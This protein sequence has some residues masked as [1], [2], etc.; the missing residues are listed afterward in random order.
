MDML[1][2]LLTGF[3]RVVALCAVALSVLLPLQAQ[4]KK[5]A[6]SKVVATVDGKAITEE[7]L[8]KAAASEL[9]SL[10]MQ[11]LQY[12]ANHARERH[13]VL[14]NSL[15]TLIEERLLAAEASR[16]GISKKDLLAAE[17]DSKVKPPSQA[18]V[19][20][21]YEANK[22]RI[23]QPREQVLPQIRQYLQREAQDKAKEEFI[24]RLNVRYGTKSSL[25]TFRLQID[26]AGHPSRG[27][28]GA[29]VTI[30]EFSD[31]QCGYCKAVESTLR[32]ILKNYP[33]QVR[34]VYRQYPIPAIHPDAFKAAEASVCAGAQGRFWEMHDL[35]FTEPG[36]LKEDALKARAVKLQLD[37]AAF[38]SCLQ[39]GKFADRVRQ[40]VRDGSRA[41]V[42]GTPALFINGRLLTG[43]Q[44]YAEIA[45]VIDEELQRNS[46]KR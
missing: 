37:A 39:S 38:N 17:V 2:K 11:K 43:A 14:L 4:D 32:E 20:S 42:S 7:E 24:Q 19:D 33:K 3:P 25:E 34:L 44:P 18:E 26:T 23:S 41:G 29:P 36:G 45:K 16:L 10:E 9:E 31:F 46:Q 1:R 13:Q 5:P 28:E 30:V 21:F 40:D 22:A 27:P 35:M 12:E 15:N 8:N 6:V